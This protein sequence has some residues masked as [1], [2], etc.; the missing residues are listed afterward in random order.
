MTVFENIAFPLRI[1]KEGANGIDKKVR[2][3][4]ALVHIDPLLDRR[5]AQLSGGQQQRISLMRAL[6]LD[7]PVLLLDEPLGSLDPIVRA[8]LQQQ[9]REIFARRGGFANGKLKVLNRI[10]EGYWTE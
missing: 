9:L 5:P 2:D 8:D 3:I 1:R 4:A 10:A 6:M 7:P